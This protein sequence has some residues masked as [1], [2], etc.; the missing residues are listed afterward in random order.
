[1][2]NDFFFFLSRMIRKYGEEIKVLYVQRKGLLCGS[3][4]V[5]AEGKGITL[6]VNSGSNTWHVL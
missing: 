4:Y 2:L 6:F 3:V 1:M 5:L